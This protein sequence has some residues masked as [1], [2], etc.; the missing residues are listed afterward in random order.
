MAQTAH[1]SDNSGTLILNASI[2]SLVAADPRSIV[3]LGPGIQ[4][5]GVNQMVL[6]AR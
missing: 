2:V 3:R 4:S 1:S 5:V 6:I